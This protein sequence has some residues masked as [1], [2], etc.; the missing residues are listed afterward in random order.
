VDFTN[1]EPDLIEENGKWFRVNG[2]ERKSISATQA[3]SLIIQG[4]RDLVWTCDD[5][6]KQGKLLHTGAAK[7]TDRI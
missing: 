4:M 7:E 3:H 6:I 1:P 2:R 5:I